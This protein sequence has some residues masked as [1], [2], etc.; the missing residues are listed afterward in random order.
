M[1]TSVLQDF[2]AEKQ[3]V[4]EADAPREEDTTLA[5]WVSTTSALQDATN[6]WLQGSWGGKGVKKNKNAKKFTKVVAGVD[7]AARKDAGKANVIINEKKDKKA[8]KYMLK[9]L[10][11]PYT[12]A[13]QYEASF[14]TPVGADWNAIATHQRATM[15]RVTKKVGSRLACGGVFADVLS[16]AAWRDHRSRVSNVLM[17]D[18]IGIVLC[19]YAGIRLDFV[20]HY[21][22][23]R[24]C[25]LVNPNSLS[26]SFTL[27]STNLST[28]PR[29]PPVPSPSTLRN[30]YLPTQSTSMFT[31]S[32]TSLRVSVNFSCE[33]A[34][35]MIPNADSSG[36]AESGETCV[37][38]RDAPSTVT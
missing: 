14:T 20:Y 3:R 28:K 8:A 37:S 21:G 22:M 10:P 29:R 4:M 19:V 9:D 31:V 18:G 6:S 15:P 27:E 23:A 26:L 5:G 38:V 36:L 33:C 35:N 11:Y 16:V 17:E 30:T 2:A 1:L 34:I 13:A 7:A 12:S 32:P 25:Y 24:S